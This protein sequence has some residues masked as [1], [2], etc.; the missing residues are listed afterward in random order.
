M[1]DEIIDDIIVNNNQFELVFND[2]HFP[3]T[4]N[5]KTARIVFNDLEDTNTDV[6]FNVFFM[7]GYTIKNGYSKYIDEVLPY[8]KKEGLRL[9]IIDIMVGYNTIMILGKF[10]KKNNEYGESFQLV[11]STEK[12]FLY[13]F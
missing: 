6:F 9:E 4:K 12:N 13:L 1:H 2:L 3:H 8:I 10:I 7:D 5:Y 11:I